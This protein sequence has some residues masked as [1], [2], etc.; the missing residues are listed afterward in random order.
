MSQEESPD[1]P[2]LIV[3][4]PGQRGM[5]ELHYAAYCNDPDAVRAQLQ[6]GGPIDVR[7]D[8]GWT[9]LHWS[10]DMAQA[11]GEPNQVVSL[12]LAAGAS[13]NSV[14]KIGVSALMMA[15]GRNNEAIL[16]QL[17][18]AGADVHTRSAGTT[19]LHEAV[20]CNFSSGIRR[21]LALGADPD[22]TDGRNRTPEQLAEECGFAECVAVF[23]AARRAGK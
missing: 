6:L 12:L 3:P 20:H 19:P 22:E 10:I 5:T 15:C 13:A 17:I 1:K 18:K 23:H 8:N 21:L 2:K 7:D 16:E 9:P 11:W 4:R 14:D